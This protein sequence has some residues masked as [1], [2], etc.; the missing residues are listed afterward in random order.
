MAVEGVLSRF[1]PEV[2]PDTPGSVSPVWTVMSEPTQMLPLVTAPVVAAPAVCAHEPELRR[3]WALWVFTALLVA[4]T[5]GVI[6]GRT[7]AD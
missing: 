2:P 6:L 4:L 7:I 3:P 5:I 1:G